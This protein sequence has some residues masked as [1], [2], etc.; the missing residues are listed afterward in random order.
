MKLKLR[1]LFSVVGLLCAALLSH[2][3]VTGQSPMAS[4]MQ[5]G[6]T[7]AAAL[8]DPLPLKG[9]G[10]GNLTYTQAEL[11][12]PASWI[13]RDAEGVPETYPGRKAYGLNAGIMHNGYFL[14]LF[15]PDSGAGPGG[16]LLYDV[17]NP[18]AIR[19]VKRLYEPEG[20]TSEFREAHS[21]GTATIGGKNFV[22]VAT[23]KG[24]EFWDFTDINDIKQVKKLALPT[25]NAGDY[26]NVSWQLWWQAP[27]VYVASANDGVYVVD[28][29]D[30]A[31]AVL[32]NRGAGKPNPVPIGELGGF[33]IGPIFTMGNHMVLSSMDNGDGFASLDI[34]DPL[35]P[36]VLDTV[37]SNPYYYA[38]CFDGLNL[39]ASARGGGAHMYSYNLADRSRF[40]AEDNRLVIDEQLYCGT[41]DHYVFQG[42]QLKVHK[43][44][45]SNPLQHVEVGRGG[46][47]PAGSEEESH[48]DH[49][50][51][52]PF[53]NLLFIGNDHG[54]GSG[55]MV[56]A[57]APDTT[58]PVVKQVSPA[59]GA[60]QQAL[61]SRI[62]LGLSDSILPE[63]VHSGSFIVRQVGGNTI[64]GTYSVQLG[65]INFF[66]S[67][68][69]LPSTEYEVFLPANGVKDYAGNAIGA[70]FHSTFTTGNATD[71]ALA[72]YWT[73]AKTLADQVGQNNGTATASDAFESIGLNFAQRT[74]GVALKDD[75]VASVLGGTASLSFYMK[76]TQVG[77][78]A[79]WTAPGIFGR[80][81]NGGGDDVFWGWIDNNG[82][83]N[84]SVGDVAA[85]NPGTKSQTAVN[86]GNWRHV[87]MTRDAASGAQAVYV[88]G[89]KTSSTGRAGTLGLGNRFQLLG[90]IQGN[91]N[92]FKGVLADVRVYN[93]VLS[94][95]D[96]AQLRVLPVVGD[97]AL[98]AGPKLVN[99][100]L[101]F[102][103]TVLGNSAQYSWNFGDGTR[104]AFASQPRITY[105][106]TRPGHYNVTLT[107]RNA[108]GA[109]SYYTYLVTVIAPVTTI[110]PTHATNITGDAST[111]YSVNPD[112]G[113]VAAIDA[114]TMVRRWEVRVG[115]EPRTLAVGP[116]SRI[117]V[118]VQDE[119]KLVVL[120]PADGSVSTTV[121]LAYGSGPYGVVFTPDRSKGL[122][123]L[124]NKSTLLSFDPA[125]GA[126]T[127]TLV[128]AGAVRGIAV[129]ADSQSAYVTRFK[130]SMSGGQLHKVSLQPLSS[131]ATIAL[132]VDTTT[133][134]DE[135]RARGVPNYLNQVVISPD[136][137]RAILPSKKDNILRGQHRDG[138]PLEH[139]RT[140]RSILSQVDLQ[141]AAEVF[142]EQ[143]DFDDRAPAR[144]ALYAP[145]GDYVFVAQMEGNRV[146][147]V[148]AYTRAVR[149]EITDVG[150]APH[151][152]Y[153]DPA[154]KR[155]FV[156]NFLGR[157][158][159]VHDVAA[160]LSSE[161]GAATKL[162]TVS[163]V[164][165]EPLT[166][167]ALRGKQLFYNAAD[168]RMS[169]DNYMS[170][171]SCHADGGDDGMV[172]DFTQRGE[173][174]RRTVNLQGRQGMGHGRVH[175]TANFD[176]LQ[177]FE[178]DIR[179][180]FGGTGFM[181][182]ADFAAASD[183]LGSPKAGKSPQ[184][185][186]LAIYLSSLSR[187]TRSPVRNAD[188]SL[189]ANAVRG[190]AVFAT[191]Q[192]GTCHT[193]ITLRDGQR[194]DVGT[195]QASSGLGIGQ[196]L[197]GVGFD[198]PTLYGSWAVPVYFHNGQ[199]ATLA[200]VFATSG[201]GNAG[202]LP[203]ADLSALTDYVRSL[204]ATS[205]QL[206]IRS[207]HSNMCV[208]V[209]GYVR[210]GGVVIQWPCGNGDNE[211]FTVNNID[212]HLQFVFKHSG[213][214]LAQG[215]T[216]STGGPVVQTACTSDA[217]TQWSLS[218]AVLRNRGSG[219]C[220]DVPNSSQT[221]DTELI[222]W[223]CNSGN[224][225]NWTLNTAGN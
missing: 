73:L 101:E 201:H 48:S 118:T 123:T 160:I 40:V 28:A 31:N 67:Q 151:G 175:W 62:G 172:W 182:N 15:A 27:Y 140:V 35:N 146:A 17:S 34:S 95:N 43:V 88:D 105:T 83:L 199:A 113:T 158:V 20:R 220:L 196:S 194:H 154:R 89:V 87:V 156:N 211:Q 136:G 135:S 212:G 59:A 107:V 137:R 58:R 2:A 13:R 150:D 93:R 161:S 74:G 41:Q 30:P 218:G 99:G 183:P 25:V 121:T 200:N 125:S 21:F 145:S 129:G 141:Q 3:A 139:D 26:T 102:N 70:D 91:T 112:S 223:S 19:L 76:T 79:P 86:D 208:N 142:A 205:A 187:Y 65:I 206:R 132:R 38:T 72:H 214:C 97:P 155:L 177:D 49:G 22:V 209:R 143:L 207:N 18:R 176:E 215:N 54:S 45:V 186:D 162:Q 133:V 126:T 178:N 221:Q 222:T 147:I 6:T 171:A 47:F 66:P 55:F 165:Q 169:R 116:D 198:T 32:A 148:D 225:Q 203:A 115:R 29:R 96:V 46:M 52:A 5:L 210:S 216:T 184:L 119:D 193:D 152:L 159:T 130:S 90:Q 144:A 51:V 108:N 1:H 190:K 14:T 192:C 131:A 111:V 39:H 168:R 174:L 82:Q 180:A 33:R 110:A 8:A 71:I 219:A 164:A 37:G 36:K 23:T 57:T 98:G 122:L 92:F 78:N 103:P 128:L 127:A 11:F 16:F 191:A 104:S 149:G 204:D 181:S 120:N 80:D 167:A 153:L 197:A 44:D 77:T 42:A 217:T 185:D 85:N 7:A 157:S 64:G 173:G 84:L 138:K 4:L 202:S 188:G 179:G 61:T 170:C 75:N 114:Q 213:L 106:Y 163:T 134:D 69:L 10:L 166:A 12:K 56:H 63:S 60:R 100:Q 224:N 68:P 53:G 24:I 195:I 9:P 124:E 50:Q 94:D 189:T 81:Q 109:E 117:W